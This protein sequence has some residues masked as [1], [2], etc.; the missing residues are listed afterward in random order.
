MS[1]PAGRRAAPKEDERGEMPFLDHLEELR[2]RILKSLIALVVGVGVG[3]FASTHVDLIAFL[4]RP[5]DPL[6]PGGKQLL[7]TSPLEPFIIVL[8]LALAIGLVLALPVVLYQVWAFLRPALYRRER[9]VVL[10]IVFS[11]VGLFV[12]GAAVGF[13]LVLPLALPVLLGFATRSLAPMIT[14]DTYFNLTLTVVLLFGVVFEV[15]LL[16]F[17]LIYLG[18]VS[19]AFLRRHHRTFI[20]INAV[21]SAILTPGDL[22]VMTLLAMI[23]VQ[24]FYELSIVMALIMERRRARRAQEPTAAEAA[25]G[26]GEPAP[27]RA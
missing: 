20:M 16:M 10:P 3:Y 8:K 18:I 21:A 6:L 4:K 25:S 12:V 17:G 9:R 7:F 11:G 14:A 2:W 26:A 15:P 22:I 5:I 13:Y 23:P 1:E 19:S 24:L 27:G